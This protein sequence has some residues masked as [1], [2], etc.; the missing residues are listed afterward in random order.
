MADNAPTITLPVVPLPGTDPYIW[1]DK[2]RV[3]LLL[4]LWGKGWSAAAIADELGCFPL[5]LYDDGGRSACLGKLHRLKLAG[6]IPTTSFRKASV[7]RP[8]RPRAKVVRIVRNQVR[9][10]EAPEPIVIEMDDNDPI[11]LAHRKTILELGNVHCRFPLGEALDPALWFCGAPEA[12]LS[13]G[14]PYCPRHAKRA[15]SRTFYTPE[16]RAAYAQ[17]RRKAT[18]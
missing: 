7:T 18:L 10:V 14:V 3:A 11:A 1:K 8:K 9:P 12:D 4:D 6:V 5:N 2:S 16:Q 17:E 15:F 13:A